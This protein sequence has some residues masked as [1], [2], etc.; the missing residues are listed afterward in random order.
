[1]PQFSTALLLKTDTVTIRDVVCDGECRHRSGEECAHKT[2][3]VYPYRGV[4]MRHVGRSDTVAEANQMLF[5]N[6]G[7]GYQRE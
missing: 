2:S 1:M 4:F 6:A 5:F 3:L 7:Q